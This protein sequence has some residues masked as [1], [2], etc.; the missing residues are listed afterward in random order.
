MTLPRQSHIF[1]GLL[2]LVLAWLLWMVFEPF[3][4]LMVTGVFVA[5]LALP[6]DRFFERKL[7][8][9]ASAAVTMLTLFLIMVIPIVGMGWAL[10]GDARA[11]AEDLQEGKANEW[12]DQ[13]LE[14]PLVQRGLAMAYPEN[15]TEE[16]NATVYEK[17][18]QGQE[19]LQDWLI[20]LGTD[21]AAKLPDF[22]IGVVVILFVVYYVLV[23]G[24]TLVRFLRRVAPLPG[25]QVDRILRE[26]GQGLRGVFVGQILTSLIQG[27]LGG[28]GFLIVGLPGAVLWAGVMAILSLLPV[29]GAF[30]VWI[31]AVIYLFAIGEI[32]Q[33]V[34]LLAWG[35]IVVSQVDNLVRPK[36]I[37]DRAA[38]HPMF[39]LVG[40][41]G[42]VAAFG[43][44]GL[45]LGPLI[46]GVA[47][48]VLKVWEEEYLDESVASR[49]A[50]ECE[51]QADEQEA[52]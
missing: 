26:A 37:G 41:L 34:F 39:V 2:L 30:L 22:F 32:W 51:G 25:P 11:I 38:I 44:I 18:A 42:G 15:T 20:D 43:F 36:L 23:D 33:A 3:V 21:V 35:V 5:V 48:S 10:V 16:R 47:V 28:V 17:A 27:A 19:R 24:E 46:V 50:V 1:F 40:V 6:I 9:R 14:N 4:I 12:I 49:P 45:F 8:N 52:A 31:P 7:P 29:I 13:A